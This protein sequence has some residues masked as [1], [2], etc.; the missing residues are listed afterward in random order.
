ME[1]DSVEKYSR[2][3]K[4]NTQMFPDVVLAVLRLKKPSLRSFALDCEVVACE[5]EKQQIFHFQKPLSVM[6]VTA[7]NNEEF[8][9][10]CEVGIG[11]SEAMLKPQRMFVR[12]PF[13]RDTQMQIPALLRV[14]NWHR[15][16]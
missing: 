13:K 2:D 14:C 5:R 12:S 10:S 16:S 1:D 9:S 8:Q 11:F 4:H 3:T 7:S 6:S 15:G